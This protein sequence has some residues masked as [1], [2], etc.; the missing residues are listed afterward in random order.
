MFPAE[1]APRPRS[2]DRE[3]CPPPS[4]RRPGRRC[5]LLSIACVLSCQYPELSESM[6]AA[7]AAVDAATDPPVV[8]RADLSALPPGSEPY[9]P[10]VS[11]ET[12]RICRFAACFRLASGVDSEG[13]GPFSLAPS[14]QPCARRRPSGG[15]AGWA[16]FSD[17]PETCRPAP[18]FPGSARSWS[19]DRVMSRAG[20]RRRRGARP[21]R[22]QAIERRGTCHRRPG[23]RIDA[24]KM[25]VAARAMAERKTLGPLPQRVAARLRS[26][27][28]PDKISMRLRR[29]HQ[30]LPWLTGILRCLRPGM[31]GGTSPCSAA[32]P[33]TNR[34]P[35]RDPRAAI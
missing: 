30:R 27:S 35:S 26:L 1:A 9:V 19:N 2:M 5:I 3:A 11:A 14:G 6:P 16:P 7:M 23:V 8:R 13:I 4:C 34:H 31:H 22:M 24:Q 18:V 32:L 12:I 28:L 25:P 33:G 29:L 21:D 20:R 17:A 10:L 15:N